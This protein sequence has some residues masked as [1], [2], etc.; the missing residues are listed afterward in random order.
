[1]ILYLHSVKNVDKE[2]LQ[3]KLFTWMVQIT[4]IML[5]LD[6][7]SRFDGKPDTIYPILNHSGNLLVFL[8]N[9]ILPSLWFAYVHYNVF[10]VE[11]KTKRLYIPL[12]ILHIVNATMVALS[13]YFG[14]F[15][16][17]DIDNIYHRGPLYLLSASVSVFLLILAFGLILANRKKIE[18]KHYFS[19]VF[20]ALPPFLSIIMQITFYGISLILN[21]VALSLLIVFINIQ[22]ENIYT[23]FLTGVNNRKKLDVVLREK[24]SSTTE[25]K[26]F[27]A[28]MIDLNDFKSINDT[29][30]HDMGDNALQITTK[31]LSSCLRSNDF[32]SR[33]GGDE[34]C[35]I[36]DISDNN[37]LEALVCRINNCFEK[38][39][40]SSD[41]PYKIGFSMGYAV[42]DYHSHMNAE[43]FKKQIDMLMYENKKANKITV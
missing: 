12:F 36:L 8:L 16:Y 22:M 5:I 14:W 25:N 41:Q 39:N 32:I 6:I 13:Q 3:N 29:Y 30:G 31:L 17:I 23:D 27:S 38:Y 24:I 4:I 19:L 9:P 37:E 43:E 15:Y 21:S 33:F 18:R 42:Y 7:F 28:I 1:M 34:F 10:Q 35:I 26:S 2:P 11:E 40:V 20:F